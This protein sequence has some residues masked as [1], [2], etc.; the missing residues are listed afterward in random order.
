MFGKE[1]GE[2]A[3]FIL[4]TVLEF[5]VAAFIIWGLFNES[6]LVRFEDR[7]ADFVKRRVRR[8]YAKRNEYRHESRGKNDRTCA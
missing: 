6:R 5:S 7:I 1:K 4:Q 3:M 8:S 2:M